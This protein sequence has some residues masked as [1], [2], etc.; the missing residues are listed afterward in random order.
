MGA[1]ADITV[2]DPDK[3]VTITQSILHDA[4]DYTPYDGQE[5]TGWP[6]TTISRGNVVWDGDEFLGAA[7]KGEFL[8][9]DTPPALSAERRPVTAFDPVTGVLS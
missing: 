2:W 1:D 6:V 9:C 8:P 5:V 4:M 3:Q 7:G